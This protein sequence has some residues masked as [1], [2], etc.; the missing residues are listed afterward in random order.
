MKTFKFKW[1]LGDEVFVGQKDC[2]DET[3]LRVHVKNLGGELI[4]ILGSEE[5]AE[6]KPAPAAS[7]ITSAPNAPEEPAHHVK[8]EPS[9]GIMLLGWY[10]ILM[11]NIVL[12]IFLYFYFFR[13]VNPNIS[14]VIKIVSYDLGRWIT[15][16]ILILVATIPAIIGI[17]LLFLKKWSRIL[18]LAFAWFEIIGSIYALFF[19]RVSIPIFSI[20]LIWFF[21]RYSIKRQFAGV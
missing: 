9:I 2:A 11:T 16:P 19:L 13:G 14:N 12:A 7:K 6:I 20:F 18:V 4:E 10:Y 8:R 5:V 1:K 17:G 15:L 3:V 21:N